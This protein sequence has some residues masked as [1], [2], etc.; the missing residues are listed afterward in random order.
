MLSRVLWI[1]G[2]LGLA[3]PAV[4]VGMLTLPNGTEPVISIAE[5][6]FGVL[7]IIIIA[8]ALLRR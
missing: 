6:I 1:C 5:I 8:R 4:E 2:P 7:L 3:L